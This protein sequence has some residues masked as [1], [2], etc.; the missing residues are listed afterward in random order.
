MAGYCSA[1]MEHVK[2]CI[3]CEASIKIPNTIITC[4]WCGVSLD[5]ATS[6]T[7][8]NGNKPVC[9]LCLWKMGK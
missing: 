8:L 7:Y 4:D 3:Q 9:D 1:H 5:G 2:G 6:D